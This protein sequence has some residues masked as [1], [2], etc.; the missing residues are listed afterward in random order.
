MARRP[1]RD[2]QQRLHRL[3]VQPGL[4]GLADPAG[5][6]AAEPG[7]GTGRRP[8]RARPDERALPGARL[9]QALALQVPVGLEHGVRVHR[10]RGHD[11]PHARKLV[12]HVEDAHPQRLPHLPHDL[13]VRRH[14]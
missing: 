6:A 14:P 1:Q 2:P 10:H 11:L 13:Q 3:L 12:T 4:T 7:M 5:Q 8:R 9:D